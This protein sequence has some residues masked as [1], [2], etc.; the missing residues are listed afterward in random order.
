MKKIL[1]AVLVLNL[2]SP[3][4]SYG[5]TSGD[6][7]PRVPFEIREIGLKGLLPKGCK[8]LDF[9]RGEGNKDAYSLDAY[10]CDMRSESYIFRLQIDINTYPKGNVKDYPKADIMHALGVFSKDNSDLE[11][12]GQKQTNVLGERYVGIFSPDNKDD[13]CSI[14]FTAQQ[15]DDN[16]WQMANFTEKEIKEQ[17][18][19]L[20]SLTF[21]N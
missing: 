8:K 18:K 17:N 6:D 14:Q 3:F 19:F 1:T 16:G 21:T 13:I 7:T 20:A 15:K 4:L 10:I 11:I 12:L 9:R 5:K 2:F